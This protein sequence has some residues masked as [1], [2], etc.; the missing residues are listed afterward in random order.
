[1]VTYI[2]ENGNKLEKVFIKKHAASISG[3]RA[4]CSIDTA[5]TDKQKSAQSQVWMDW[6]CPC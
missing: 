6:H 4:G 2:K 1:M 5:G 3:F